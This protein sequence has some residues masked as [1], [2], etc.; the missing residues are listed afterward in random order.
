[1]SSIVRAQS[2]LTPMHRGQ[3]PPVACR[4]ARVD[5]L[6]RPSGRNAYPQRDHPINHHVAKPPHDRLADRDKAGR[7]RAHNP[8]IQQLLTTEA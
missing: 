4:H 1:M 8:S 6:Q 3:L 7:P 2:S 5:G